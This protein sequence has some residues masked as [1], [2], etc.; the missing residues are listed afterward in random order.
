MA[1][2][3]LRLTLRPTSIFRLTPYIPT[4]RRTLSYRLSSS[5]SSPSTPHQ[6][7]NDL[8]DPLSP[9]IPLSPLGLPLDPLPLPPPNALAPPMT[10]E[11]L[12][13]LHRLSA[14]NPPAGGSKEEVELIEGL[15]GLVG[16]MDAVKAVQLPEGKGGYGALL[17]RG[18][19]ELELDF[20]ETEKTSDPG[21]AVRVDREGGK[22]DRELL[23]YATR[24]VGDYYASRLPQKPQ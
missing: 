1:L 22:R 2:A 14:L 13:R 20:T 7:P 5:K 19:G 6:A 10:R 24:R 18:V 12:H 21:Q 16:L 23:Q 11:A 15:R 17:G 8:S 4:T 3:A 9:D